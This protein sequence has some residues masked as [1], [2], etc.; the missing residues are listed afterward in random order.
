[1]LPWTCK[2][3]RPSK[4]RRLLATN[5]GAADDG[6]CTRGPRSFPWAHERGTTSKHAWDV[7]WFGAAHYRFRAAV[8]CYAADQGVCQLHDISPCRAK[9]L[10]WHHADLPLRFTLH[11]STA[12]IPLCP[13]STCDWCVTGLQR[14]AR[15]PPSKGSDSGEPECWGGILKGD[16]GEHCDRNFL[17]GRRHMYVLYAQTRLA[18]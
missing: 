14:L 15:A 6:G 16:N 9:D 7:E 2:T 10:S 18:Q 17:R 8:A 5:G 1:M 4:A 12:D 11:Q 3:L 13:C